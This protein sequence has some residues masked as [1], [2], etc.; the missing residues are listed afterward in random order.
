VD[1]VAVLFVLGISILF[2]LVA[3]FLAARLIR[4]TGSRIPWVLIAASVT[5]MALRRGIALA[6]LISGDF[7]YPPDPLAE[8]VAFATSTIMLVGIALIAPL[9]RS[10]QR[11][12]DALRE[13]EEKYRLL[14]ETAMDI[15]FAHEMDGRII[16]ANRTG[17]E[18]SGYGEEELLCMNIADV[19]PS[20][21]LASMAERCAGRSSGDRGVH[22]YQAEFVDAA[23]RRIPVEVSSS[24]LVRQDEPFGMLIVARDITDRKRV[25]EELRQ[26]NRELALLNRAGQA[27][28]STLD[29]DQV[30]AAVLEEVRRLLDVTAS[31]VWLVEPETGELICQQATGPHR[32]AVR[33]WR[34]AP[35]EGIAGWVAG[36]GESLIVSDTQIDERHFKG[37]DQQVGLE[38]RS[39][40]S[41]PLRVKKEVI[42]VLQVLDTA[43]NRFNAADVTLLGLLAASAAVAIDNARLVEAMRQYTDELKV[44]NE[45]LDAFAHTVAHDLKDP[46]A[47]VVGLAEVLREESPALSDEESRRYLRKMAQSGRKMSNI[48]DELMLL[49]GVRKIEVEMR[50]L[51]M[52]SIVAEAMQRL[53][54]VIEEH[55]AEIILPGTWPVAWGYGPWVEE[56][57]VNYLSN[58]LKYGGRPPRVELGATAQVDGTVRFWVRDNGP[59]LA[60]EEQARLFTPFT[61]L[62]HVRVKGHG[63]GL[64]IVRRI[65]EKLDGQVG[66]E[67][68]VGQGSVFSFTLPGAAD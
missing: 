38:L 51:D 40:L 49:A 27:L 44:R 19:I 53:A 42:G 45:E 33:G 57:W 54:D 55:Q 60:P 47:I 48:V 5:L 34:L 14:T 22:L 63:L 59:G 50:P 31:S 6:R 32:D 66:V 16:Y 30:L 56:V 9:F 2:Q 43:V 23:G 10:I 8:L 68:E 25:E 52:G 39:I 28:T 13:S 64:S 15:I 18:I 24:P 7:A 3:A 26:R 20:E 37:V 36:S 46:L 62:E 4:V 61:R 67:S 35:G 1:G 29:L 58:A 21:Y 41:V 11:S 65:V 12:E 17:Q